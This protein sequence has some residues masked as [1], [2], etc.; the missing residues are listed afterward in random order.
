MRQESFEM[1][2]K[3]DGM[4]MNIHKE[5]NVGIAMKNGKLPFVHVYHQES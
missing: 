3:P 1:S 2:H 4:G 5:N